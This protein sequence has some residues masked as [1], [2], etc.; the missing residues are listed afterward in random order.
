M[1]FLLYSKYFKSENNSV[2]LDKTGTE[3]IIE[4]NQIKNIKYESSDD[5]G[6]KYLIMAEVGEINNEK[7]N[8]INLNIVNA[9]ITLNN[10]SKILI[11]SNEAEY[12]HS[13]NNTKFK[14]NVELSHNKQSLK[15]EFLNL[16]FEKNLVEA[17]NNVHY[18]NDEL[19]LKADKIDMNI[20]TKNFKIYNFS[21]QK[22]I[23]ES[24]D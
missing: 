3:E 16:E 8:L 7:P 17:F 5:E 14:K 6:R 18:K 2:I 13:T 11:S 23:I 22:V 9:E 12:N 20:K 24:L 19:S 21:D 1:I 4:G 10:N 15:A